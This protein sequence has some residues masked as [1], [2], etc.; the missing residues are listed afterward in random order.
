MAGA[1]VRSSDRTL[2]RRGAAVTLVKAP[3][4]V[5]LTNPALCR[6]GVSAAKLFLLQEFRSKRSSRGSSRGAMRVIAD[7]YRSLTVGFETRE[8]SAR[9]SLR[10][11]AAMRLRG[12]AKPLSTS[13]ASSPSPFGAHRV[14]FDQAKRGYWGFYG[15]FPSADARAIIWWLFNNNAAV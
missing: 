9:G 14:R 8:H 5:R 4:A 7:V 2:F 1:R 3:N 11:R 15:D 12:G 6:A 10:H 13:L